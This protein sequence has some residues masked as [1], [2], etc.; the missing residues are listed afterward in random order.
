MNVHEALIKR[1]TCRAFKPDSVSPE[2]VKEILEWANRTPSWGN[3]QP[4]QIYVAGGEVLESLRRDSLERFSKGVAGKLDLP[5]P[6]DW[7]EAMKKRYDAVGKERFALL[8][9]ELDKD[10]IVQSIVARNF[11]FFDAPVVVYLCMDRSL[12]AYSMYDLGALSQSIMLAAAD[13]GLDTA[14]A[15]ML[16]QYPDMIRDALDIPE[17]LAIVVGIALGYGDAG[18]IHNRLRTSRRPLAEVVTMKGF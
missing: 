17:E 1:Y 16:V 12:T 7:P 10:N 5:I 8:S 11:A 15:I 6:Q 13:R 9:Q 14:P 2:I 3:T 4:W 18:S